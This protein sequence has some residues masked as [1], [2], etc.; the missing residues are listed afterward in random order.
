M[1]KRFTLTITSA[2]A[3]ELTRQAAFA[4]KPGLMH[5]DFLE[6]SSGEGWFHIR[7]QP[8]QNDGVP[9]ARI[10]GVTLYAPE[11]QLELLSGLSLNYYGDLSGGG[12]VITPPDHSESCS[13]GSGFRYLEKS[14]SQ[15][16]SH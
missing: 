9:V 8:G 12:F 4:G 11:G 1:S 2:A 3:A 14:R 16:N 6:D 10:D 13:C 5:L 7:L 15:K